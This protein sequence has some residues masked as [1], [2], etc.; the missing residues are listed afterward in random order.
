MSGPDT[1]QHNQQHKEQEQKSEDDNG[2]QMEEAG[3]CGERTFEHGSKEFSGSEQPGQTQA[4]A[5]KNDEADVIR[6]PNVDEDFLWIN[7]VI[8]GNGVKARFEF[9]EKE[10]LDEEQKDLDETGNETGAPE[11]EAM[12]PG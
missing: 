3:F 6:L 5:D 11:E 1:K 9:V 8:D 10:K 7:Q 2:G 4:Q 12:P